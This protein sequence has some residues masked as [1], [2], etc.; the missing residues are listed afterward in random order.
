MLRLAP[1]KKNGPAIRRAIA[2]TFPLLL[3]DGCGIASVTHGGDGSTSLK[4]P[5]VHR[6]KAVAC[7]ATRQP[8][9]PNPT[10]TAGSP[11][12]KDADCTAGANGRC[13]YA[14]LGGADP[15][16][17]LCS[18]DQCATDRDCG[19]SQVCDCRSAS[20]RAANVCFRGNCQTDGDCGAGGWCSPSA[21]SFDPTCLT[22]IEPGQIGFFCHTAS[23]TCTD[24]ADCTGPQANR[25]LF[26]VTAMRWQ[27]VLERCTF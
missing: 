16:A 24:D 1:P 13:I 21:T 27:C 4:E 2:V 14:P 12:L 5:Q 6:A 17:N 3:V 8:G 15:F 19:L 9:T 10:P 25:C 22:G 23:D 7:T 20:A 11:C 26:S 18:Y